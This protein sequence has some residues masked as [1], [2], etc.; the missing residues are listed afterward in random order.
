MRILRRCGE[1]LIIVL[2]FVGWNLWVGK[3]DLLSLY[4]PVLIGSLLFLV[5][6]GMIDG[7]ARF[8]EGKKN[9]E[10]LRGWGVVLALLMI[11][12]VIIAG[13]E[14]WS[15]WLLLAALAPFLA[16]SYWSHSRRTTRNPQD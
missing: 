4:V 9:D 7:L 13:F 14:H 3:L 12:L 5:L 1:A 2:F 16:L 6:F 8:L 15:I 10:K 11:L